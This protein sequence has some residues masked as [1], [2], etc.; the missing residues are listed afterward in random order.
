MK[1]LA[2]KG[3]KEL[4]HFSFTK[5][6]RILKR[7]QYL[8]LSKSG[9]KIHNRYF[10]AIISEN[11]GQKSRL[12]ITVSKKVGKAATRNRIKR[13]SREFFRLNRRII[14]G[15]WDI[16]LIAKREAA[17]LENAEAGRVLAQ[18]FHGI[19]KKHQ[20]QTV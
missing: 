2:E 5:A 10:T 17:L 20:R 8:E 7:R 16:N 15:S 4:R 6:D 14:R 11:S 9:L 19:S 18:L 1:E 13:F 3:I 12:G